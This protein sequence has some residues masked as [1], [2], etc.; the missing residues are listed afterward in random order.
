MSHG[1]KR[2]R[3]MA[4]AGLGRG[5]AAWAQAQCVG[6]G[7]GLGVVRCMALCV[8]L[9]LGALAPVRAQGPAQAAVRA[10]AP[11]AAAPGIEITDQRAVTQRFAAVPQRV[12][13]LLPSLTESLC[14]L[15]Q[16]ARLVGVD[17]YSNHPEPVRALPQVGGGLDPQIEAVVALRPDVVLISQSS[18]AWPQLEA[19]GL[20]VVVLEPRTHADVQRTLQ[21]LGRL[22]DVPPAQGAERVWRDIEAAVA[23]EAAALSPAARRLRV[24]F[25]VS[26]GPYGASETSFIGETL[27]RLGVPNVVPGK[28]GPF[29][30]LNP[31]FVVRADPDVILIGNRSMQA[32]VPYPGWADMRAVRA[33]RLCIF[34][35]DDA[36]T[37]VRPGPRM[38]QAARLL[39]QCLERQ[40]GA[41][42]N[43]ANAGNG[44]SAVSAA[45]A[46]STTTAV[47]AGAVR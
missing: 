27:Q 39:A 13:S 44:A 23:R 32:M 46:A 19:L 31:E 40:A 30:R 12:V 1:P 20:K 3:A 24:Y 45:R 33:Q 16:C 43:A 4:A 7:A 8:A 11:T 28:L 47:P 37:L 15:G 26:R 5:G 2:H 22:F 41:A 42:T 34:G 21:V 35:P 6:L 38:V 17:R 10:S 14:A 18:R 9:A 29:P 25:E 36:D